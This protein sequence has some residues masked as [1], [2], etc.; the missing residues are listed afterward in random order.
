MPT[1]DAASVVLAASTSLVVGAVDLSP[2]GSTLTLSWRVFLWAGSLGYAV[3]AVPGSAVPWLLPVG[4][5][6]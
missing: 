2:V 6:E 3:T 1:V 4:S 5:G